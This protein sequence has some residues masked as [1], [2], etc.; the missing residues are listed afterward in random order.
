MQ[1]KERKK[2]RKKNIEDVTKKIYEHRTKTGI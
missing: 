1:E 2:E